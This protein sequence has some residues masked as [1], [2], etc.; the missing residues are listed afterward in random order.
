MWRDC[1]KIEQFFCPWWLLSVSISTYFSLSH[2]LSFF[3][4]WLI[5]EWIS[6]RLD[7]ADGCAFTCHRRLIKPFWQL[8]QKVTSGGI[9]AA[10][11]PLTYT[12]KLRLLSP[13]IW[14][15]CSPPWLRGLLVDSNLAPRAR[16]A[17]FKLAPL[18]TLMSPSDKTWF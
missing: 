17:R 13:E 16:A 7:Y 15:A 1:K 2:P 18:L 8:F 3:L 9:T 6:A 12:Y 14:R 10:P 4:S 5:Q 11:I